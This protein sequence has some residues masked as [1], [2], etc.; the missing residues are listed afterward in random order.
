MTV[1][2]KVTGVRKLQKR[3][4]SKSICS[5][6]MHVIK[7]LMVNCDTQ[8]QYFF[9]DRFFYIHSHSASRDL[10]TFAILESSNDDISGMGGLR[11]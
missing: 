2:V 11:V 4:I 10:Q 5:A 3:P 8:R 7:S 6:S 1:K 9:L